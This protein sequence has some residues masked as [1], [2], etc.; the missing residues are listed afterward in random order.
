MLGYAANLRRGDSNLHLFFFLIKRTN[1]GRAAAVQINFCTLITTG[2]TTRRRDLYTSPRWGKTNGAKKLKRC[3]PT[4]ERRFILGP[5]A[6][7]KLISGISQRDNPRRC[8]V[9]PAS[10]PLFSRNLLIAR[11]PARGRDRRGG[12]NGVVSE[13]SGGESRDDGRPY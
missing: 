3:T 8:R 11:G 10:L 1:F 12:D 7:I 13:E 6:L 4:R 5:G 9:P 2:G